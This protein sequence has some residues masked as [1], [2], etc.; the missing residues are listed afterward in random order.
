M[1]DVVIAVDDLKKSY[2]KHTVLES[3]TLNVN[4]GD[5]YGLIG[6]NGAGKTT[7]FK[8]LLGLSHYDSGKL[9][10]LGAKNERENNQMRRKIGFF[11][12]ANH[13][14]YLN[15]KQNLK[16]IM[17]MKG[18]KD[19]NEA[20]RVLEIVGLN[21]K[22]AEAPAERFSLGM[23]Q[24]LGIA[25]ALLGKPEI[26]VFDEPINGLDPQGIHDVRSLIEKI[27]KE[28]GTTIIV[29][30][31]ILSEL[32]HTATR[33][34]IIHNGVV[35]KELTR[36]DFRTQENVTSINVADQD[37]DKAIKLLTDNGINVKGTEQAR[38]SLEDFYFSLI[39]G[40]GNA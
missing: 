7:L 2:G 32:E 27:N 29:S 33:F 19:K 39:G 1:S 24:R 18:I 28:E 5:I 30:S 11:V 37:V 12:G 6:K 38:S 40:E 10:I 21:T 4:K 14:G 15:A 23:K 26:L 17:K 9:S 35:L 13:Y 31:H 16:Y 22:A 20:D 36:D 25:G 34:G 3:I 8:A